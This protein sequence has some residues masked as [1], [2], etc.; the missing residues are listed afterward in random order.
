MASDI[1][2]LKQEIHDA[3]GGDEPP[4][5]VYGRI[6]IKTGVSLGPIS[7]DD[8]VSSDEYQAVVDAAEEVTGE[9]F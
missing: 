7:E 5:K 2:D 6:R 4:W 9:M 8:E 1:F 3:V